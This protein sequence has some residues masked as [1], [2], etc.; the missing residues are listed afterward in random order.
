M[1]HTIFSIAITLLLCSSIPVCAAEAT[2]D[3]L[4]PL[5][6]SAV[7]QSVKALWAGY[8]PTAESLDVKIVREWKEAG[9]TYRYLTYTIGTFK[10]KGSTMAA[11]YAFPTNHKGKLPALI[12]IHGGGQRAELRS[13]KVAAD[14]GYAGLAINWGARPMS[15]A[16]P[17]D[18]TT[19]WGAIDATQTGHVSHYRS[20]MPDAKT[21]DPFESPRNNNWFLI[22]LA[23]RRGVTFLEA[24]PEVNAE[25][26]GA[27]GHSMG[28]R[29]TVMLAGSDKRVKVASPSCGG[30]GDTPAVL[31]KRPGVS[32]TRPGSVLYSKTIDIAQ[33]A[34]RIT[35]PIQ[36]LGPQNDFHG[37]LDNLYANWAAMSSKTVGYTITPH[38]NHRM[39]NE[40][41]YASLLWF[42]AHL[43]GALK[44]PTT[45]NLVVGLKA[46]DGVPIATLQPANPGEVAKVVIYYSSDP[47]CVTRF[48]RT[49]EAKKI[50]TAWEAKLP[51]IPT[52]KTPLFVMANVEYPLTQTVVG[53][54]HTS[55]PKTYRV[56]SELVTVEPKVLVAA[57]VATTKKTTRMIEA[58]FKISRDWYRLNWENPHW[59]SMHTRK[60]KDP[61]YAAPKGATLCMDVKAARDATIIFDVS[62]NGWDAYSAKPKGQY[63]AIVNVK[64]S[65]QWQTVRVGI[66]DFKLMGRRTKTPMTSWSRITELGIVGRIRVMKDGKRIELP[67]SLK[68]PWKLPRTMRNL[69]W[70][71]GTGPGKK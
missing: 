42:E 40:S 65:P 32:L 1:R 8:D 60:V 49:A 5:T 70:E 35:V 19:D 46:K 59:W 14:N 28:G 31:R 66:S 22:T 23:A 51:E 16:K 6:K 43:K 34:K 15:T 56:S 39:D 18:P 11:Y 55:R 21:I 45:P 24:Q 53:Y 2:P 64:G 68:A 29:L 47:H 69:R 30:S 20:L 27:F 52:T 62:D 50:G 58:N 3:S 41:V 36:Y 48:W 71:G 12:Q 33:Y 54:R 13:V 37:I 4:P 61:K 7:P 44:F 67:A 38:M 17:G 10:G 9:V 57:G 26:I 25:R 63:F